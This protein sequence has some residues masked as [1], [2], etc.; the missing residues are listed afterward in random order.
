MRDKKT[1]KGSVGSKSEI[2]MSGYDVL[3]KKTD[4]HAVLGEVFQHLAKNTE[5]SSR[6]SLQSGLDLVRQRYQESDIGSVG[7]G[8]YFVEIGLQKGLAD[9]CCLLAR[10]PVQAD[11]STIDSKPIR[12]IWVFGFP[13][14]TDRQFVVSFASYLSSVLFDPGVWELLTGNEKMSSLVK[15]LE[16]FVEADIKA[17]LAVA[18]GNI[19]TAKTNYGKALE[20]APASS[21]V[22]TKVA[23]LTDLNAKNKRALDAYKNAK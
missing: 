18:G 16:K 11:W 20:I 15:K 13:E 5:S 6:L 9:Y 8:I 4:K 17:D 19:R 12:L 23:R 2:V 14:K 3:S 10:L 1:P 7:D 21:L 22:K